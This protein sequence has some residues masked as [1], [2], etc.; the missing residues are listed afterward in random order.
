MISSNE[1]KF[2]NNNGYLIKKK[3]FKKIY[4]KELFK[5]L[6]EILIKE[7]IASPKN[8][9]DWEHEVLNKKL[10]LLR[11]KTKNLLRFMILSKTASIKKF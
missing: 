11:K 9:F 6:N 7:K 2:Y 5:I 8:K 3:F 4:R 10:I 1:K